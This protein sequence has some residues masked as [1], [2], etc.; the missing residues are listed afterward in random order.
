MFL[1]PA[2][3]VG[4]FYLPQRLLAETFWPRHTKLHLMKEVGHRD[5]RGVD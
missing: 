1:R 4:L 5:H 3:H 2:A